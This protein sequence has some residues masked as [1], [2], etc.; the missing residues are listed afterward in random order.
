[1][2]FYTATDTQIIYESAKANEQT[3]RLSL[4][5]GLALNIA[6]VIAPLGDF[7]DTQVNVYC[8][9]VEGVIEHFKAPGEQICAF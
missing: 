4:S 2:G 5:V 8:G 1:V 3:R 7:A 6:G 9:S